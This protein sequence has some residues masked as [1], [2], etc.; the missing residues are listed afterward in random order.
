MVDEKSFAA[1]FIDTS[2]ELYFSECGTSHI[3]FAPNPVIA[4][5]THKP[6]DFYSML[7]HLK[8]WK[9]DFLLHGQ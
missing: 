7:A 5:H 1:D 8:K 3:L 2:K 4:A 9:V 6:E